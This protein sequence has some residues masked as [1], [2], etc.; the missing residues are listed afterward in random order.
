MLNTRRP[1]SHGG[2]EEHGG[3]GLRAVAN[4]HVELLLETNLQQPVG[5]IQDQNLHGLA[6]GRCAQ[7]QKR[8]RITAKAGGVENNRVINI[9]T[10]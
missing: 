2:R 4:D 5:F 1:T 7:V 8:S 10:T 3:T 6:C 9:V